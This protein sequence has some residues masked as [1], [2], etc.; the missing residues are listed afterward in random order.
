MRLLFA[1]TP[2]VALASLDALVASRHDIVGVLTRPP[3]PAGRGRAERPS[4]VHVRAVELGLPVVTAD[5]LADPG[6]IAAVRD[7]AP[8]CCPVVAY[9]AMITAEARAIPEYGWV[10]LHFSLLP[11]WRGAAPV[12]HAVL[13]G[14]RQAGATTFRIDAGL[15]TGPTFGSVTETVGDRDTSGDLLA[16]LAVTGAGLLVETMDSIER[17]DAEAQPQ[18]D[19]GVTLAPRIEVGD[20]RIGWIGT[21]QYVDRFVRAM[22]PAP[23]AWT[24]LR[25]ERVKIGPVEPIASADLAEGEIKAQRDY[26]H[27]GTG[28]GDVAL[29]EVQAHGKRAMPAGDWARGLRLTPGECFA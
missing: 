28:D 21:A 8:D 15:D 7:L 9:G 12:Q 13:A 26:V 22:T 10:N 2:D 6:V 11:R 5:R 16:R 17:G 3:A 14:D 20:A 23:G 4:P 24:T 27:V 19:R 29:G 1:G 18:P 25:G